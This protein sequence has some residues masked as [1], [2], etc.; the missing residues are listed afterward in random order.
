VLAVGGPRFRIRAILSAMP[1]VRADVELVEDANS[2]EAEDSAG[3]A[4]ARSELLELMELV[5]RT[6]GSDEAP[7]EV[8]RDETEL[9]WAIAANLQMRL[10]RQQ[11]ILEMDT[12][13]KRL[14]AVIP[15]L[16]KEIRHYRVM[17]AARRKLEELGFTS[18]EETPFSRS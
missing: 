10:G 4:M 6:M 8:P 13:A 18:V 15:V 17:A 1:I 3:A 7:L 12:P 9:S 11:E 16:R 5:L 2:H 14:T